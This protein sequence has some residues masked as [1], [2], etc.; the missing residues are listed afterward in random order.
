MK[1]KRDRSEERSKEVETLM[2][3]LENGRLVRGVMKTVSN[4]FEVRLDLGPASP[5]R[6]APVECA[7]R[8]YATK[9]EVKC[10]F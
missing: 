4:H 3:L 6:K 2:M 5:L 9:R 1:R 10:Q 8:S 7:I